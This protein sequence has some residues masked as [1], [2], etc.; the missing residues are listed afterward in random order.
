MTIDWLEPENVVWP[1]AGQTGP[2][3][4]IT[5]GVHEP[6]A[7]L[8]PAPAASS[9]R[10]ER[11][12]RR[13]GRPSVRRDGR[14]VG[15]GG[16]GLGAGRGDRRRHI[17]ASE[18]REPA[19]ARAWS[20]AATRRPSDRRSAAR[21]AGGPGFRAGTAA[22]STCGFV[23]PPGPPTA[24]ATAGPLRSLGRRGRRGRGPSPGLGDRRRGAV[25]GGCGGSRALGRH[26]RRGRHPGRGGDELP[27]HRAP[28]C[29]ATA[30]MSSSSDSSRSAAFQSRPTSGRRR[31]S[32][33]RS[34][35]SSSAEF[36]V[37]GDHRDPGRL[38]RARAPTPRD[39]LLG[40]V[41]PPER[42]PGQ[43]AF[44]GTLVTHVGG[45]RPAQAL[46]EP[47]RSPSGPAAVSSRSRSREAAAWRLL[48]PGCGRSLGSGAPCPAIL[49]TS[50]TGIGTRRRPS[51]DRFAGRCASPDATGSLRSKKTSRLPPPTQCEQ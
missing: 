13:Q 26:E 30:G 24:R 43:G 25:L 35:S 45:L 23:A 46:L 40:P 5:V 44:L 15:R 38:R 16:L 3:V 20:A 32:P 37:A 51:A 10:R 48:P 33:G 27:W 4:E 19:A 1:A 9:G 2:G 17:L 6:E 50:S 36:A 34:S 29:T 18:R 39:R 12:G 47:R 41:P 14:Q 49:L 42:Q 31:S 7:G 28:A 8:D 11:R 21:S 22:E